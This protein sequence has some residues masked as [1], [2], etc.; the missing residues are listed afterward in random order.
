[1]SPEAFDKEMEAVRQD[2][3]RSLCD[4]WMSARDVASRE[5]PPPSDDD[6]V[7][8]TRGQ[9]REM[10]MLAGATDVHLGPKPPLSARFK[11]S[12]LPAGDTV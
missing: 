2:F 4:M 7:T 6:E 3:D 5:I 1:M 10:L 8:M 12:R 11:V 9:L